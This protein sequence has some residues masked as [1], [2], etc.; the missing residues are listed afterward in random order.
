MP[1]TPPPIVTSTDQDQHPLL[2]PDLNYPDARH[3]QPLSDSTT[4]PATPPSQQQPGSRAKDDGDQSSRFDFPLPPRALKQTHDATCRQADGNTD[5]RNHNHEVSEKDGSNS[6]KPTDS[7][8]TPPAATAGAA[9]AA[10]AA[11]AAPV[12]IIA[13]D[14]DVDP[15]VEIDQLIAGKTDEDYDISTLKQATFYRRSGIPGARKSASG[16]VHRGIGVVKR[17]AAGRHSCAGEIAVAS[18]TPGSGRLKEDE[19]AGRYGALPWLL[20]IYSILPVIPVALP[21]TP[22]RIQFVDFPARLQG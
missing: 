1:P 4:Y 19:L 16:L 12:I 7:L 15:S 17:D 21:P 8:P 9:A 6:G 13:V 2:L 5:N 20:F 11:A 18:A 22:A 10:A 3:Y 14:T